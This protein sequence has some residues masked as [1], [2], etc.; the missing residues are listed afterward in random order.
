[1]NDGQLP[2]HVRQV[3]KFGLHAD[4]I[5]PDLQQQQRFETKHNIRK[6]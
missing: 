1:M 6:D 3:S 5:W 2:V 4:V